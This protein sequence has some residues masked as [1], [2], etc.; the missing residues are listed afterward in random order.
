MVE[1][2][3][4]TLINFDFMTK[5][6]VNPKALFYGILRYKALDWLRAHC[7][8]RETEEL[9][10]HLP[11]PD[12]EERS[13]RFEALHLAIQKLAEIPKSVVLMRLDGYS[14]KEIATILEI[15]S[16]PSARSIQCRAIKDLR[17]WLGEDGGLLG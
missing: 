7:R 8:N 5:K 16:E 10:D 6:P 12:Y 17:S 1:R 11:A 3:P 4:Q 14:Y 9:D 15:D 13:Y 2:R